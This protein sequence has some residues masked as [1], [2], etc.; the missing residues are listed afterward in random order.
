VRPR[1]GRAFAR[2]GLLGNPS[3]Q[4]EGK[5]VAL[6]VY[7]FSAEVRIEPAPELRI[8]R[9]AADRL[10]FPSFAHAAEALRAEGCYDGI[11]LL[12]AA[13]RRFSEH[14]SGWRGLDRDD[15]RLRF[16]LRYHTDVPRQVGLA[17]SSAIVI[18]ALR[19][20]ASW[21]ETELPPFELAER[22]LEAEVEDLGIAAGPMDRAVQAYEGL[23]AMDFR[24]PRTPASYRRL[25][26]G[27]LP[28]LFV[29]WDPRLGIASGTVHR[30]MRVRW[31]AGDPALRKAVQ[32][33]CALVDEGMRCL[34]A[35]NLQGLRRCVDRNFDTRASV[36]PIAPRDR[37][38]VD[39]GRAAGAAVK[40]CGSGGAVL[41]VLHEPEEFEAMER[42]YRE[43]GFRARLL[44]RE[45]PP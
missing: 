39:L 38:M 8:L 28:P 6:S 35:Q 24:P 10:E 15:P 3:D 30:D 43:A 7:A 37:Q 17:G 11:R 44:D 36:W 13:L 2:A 32:T 14:W 12:R 26:P 40:F 9:G 1:T 5:A 16:A 23:L 27:L 45:P 4:F 33:L 25:D 34:E 41:G 20:L 22:A 18:A 31:L 21:F 29:A 42:A 19:A